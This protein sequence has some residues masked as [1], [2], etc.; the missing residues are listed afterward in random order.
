M[1]RD[2]DRDREAGEPANLERLIV[3][4][5]MFVDW[6]FLFSSPSQSSSFLPSPCP[7]EIESLRIDGGFPISSLPQ[8]SGGCRKRQTQQAAP[9]LPSSPSDAEQQARASP[10]MMEAPGLASSLSVSD[11]PSSSSHPRPRP[12]PR[13]VPPSVHEHSR[14]SASS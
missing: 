7:P 13:P 6:K 1:H 12:R 11:L 4:S 3:S 10:A 14:S 9:A 2:R 5:S 8:I